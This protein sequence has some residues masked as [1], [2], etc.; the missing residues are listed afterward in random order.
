MTSF[1]NWRVFYIKLA[2]KCVSENN[3]KII[4]AVE[5]FA[6]SNL[7]QPEDDELFFFSLN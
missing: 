6:E 5:P 4:E 3:I 1:H 2:T 7:S